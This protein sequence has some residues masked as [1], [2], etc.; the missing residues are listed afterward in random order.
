MIVCLYKKKYTCILFI[1]VEPIVLRSLVRGGCC[2]ILLSKI[3]ML[4][5]ISFYNTIGAYTFTSNACLLLWSLDPCLPVC[6]LWSV[7][8]RNTTQTDRHQHKYV[9]TGPLIYLTTGNVLSCTVELL[10]DS[11][12]RRSGTSPRFFRRFTIVI[13]CDS[14]ISACLRQDSHT[15]NKT[16]TSKNTF[17]EKLHGM[18]LNT[19]IV[20]L[21]N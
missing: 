8:M 14:S 21:E 11:Y 1:S 13:T 20:Y 5:F 18:N 19:P 2:S 4:E 17:V 10:V 9:E 16:S 12:Y 7:T 3:N 15:L 6:H